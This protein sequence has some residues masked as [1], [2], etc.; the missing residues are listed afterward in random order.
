MGN[1]PR[2]R[3]ARILCLAIC[4]L[5]SL[6]PKSARPAPVW[7]ASYTSSSNSYDTA[8]NIAIGA[9]HTV[10][11]PPRIEEWS[12]GPTNV[13]VVAGDDLV[14]HNKPSGDEPMT[15]EWRKDGLLLV[16]TNS[17]LF[18]ERLGAGQAGTY[19][20]IARNPYGVATNH[21]V[22]VKVVPRTAIDEWRWL[23][24]QPQGNTLNAVAF[25]NGTFVAIGDNGTLLTSTNG[26]N[27]AV[28]RLSRFHLTGVSFGNGTFVA[29][30]STGATYTSVDGQSW[31]LRL[32]PVTEDRWQAGVSFVNG[33]FITCGEEIRSSANG[34]VWTNHGLSPAF[35]GPV[36][37][38]A[39]RYLLPSSQ[40][41]MISTNLNDW[42]P[43]VFAQNIYDLRSAAFGNGAFVINNFEELYTLIDG[44]YLT[45]RHAVPG[46]MSVAYV[47]GRFFAVGETIETSQDGFT[48]TRVAEGFPH[49][50]KSIT[51]GNNLYVTVGEGGVTATST[52]GQTWTRPVHSLTAIVGIAHGN[53]RYVA[54]GANEAWISVDGE[55]WNP[56]TGLLP[57]RP[58]A[59][60]WAR[61][62]FVVVGRSGELLTSGDGTTW[63]RVNLTDRDLRAVIHDGSRFVVVGERVALFSTN[64]VEW[65]AALANALASVRSLAFGNGLY[66]MSK[67]AAGGTQISTNGI[68]W[69][70]ALDA[71]SA[72][73]WAYGNGTF[74]G[75]MVEGAIVSTDGV[76]WNTHKISSDP[77]LYFQSVTF[78]NGMFVASGGPF[79]AIATSTDGQQW[80][81]HR[82]R[83][84]VG[85]VVYT[86]GA[87]WAVGSGG[88]AILHSAQIV[89]LLRGRK[90]AAGFELTLQVY[91]GQ[92]Y[93]LQRAMSVGAW[94]DFQTV[95]PQ[96]ET[97][98]LID[99]NSSQSAFYRVI[100][101]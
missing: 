71:P 62:T 83:A 26:T 33:M 43:H 58:A 44:I 95:T 7:V 22:S 37:F 12:I 68:N 76:A 85:P 41:S 18:V 4:A 20:G 40:F 97:T 65:T 89:P 91:P 6:L 82:I 23:Q 32:S 73:A 16:A 13:T 75:V 79:A 93:R 90:S 101:P 80:I 69:Q 1:P 61:G 34:I 15:F 19:M 49:L 2:R 45:N 77:D 5:G 60:T 36:A 50:L 47:N 28:T 30:A 98:S 35:G 86:D 42:T 21:P 14:L 27:W 78:A 9:A 99:N 48:W 72:T 74:V 39:G 8:E 59:I 84:P 92:S 51:Y 31:T 56:A 10:G 53:G 57:Q 64:G 70:P 29:A 96:T 3:F 63:T 55:V 24:P 81:V 54:V 67:F 52:D 38:G 66:V 25:G 46:T 17:M 87:F 100:S 88:A 11:Q 94:S